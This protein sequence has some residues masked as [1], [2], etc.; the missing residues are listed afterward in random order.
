M[1]KPYSQACE[2]NKD[3]IL[4]VL[5]RHLGNVEDVLEIGSGTGQHAVHFARHLPH[6]TWRTSDQVAYHEGIRAWLEDSDLSNVLSPLTLNVTM[7]PWPVDSAAAVFSANTAHIMSWPMVEAFIS[8]VGRIL[9]ERGLFLLYGP[10]SYRGIH[11]S[12]SNARFDRSLREQDPAMGV[13]DF[14][15][16]DALARAASLDFVEDNAMPA[17]NRLLVWCRSPDQV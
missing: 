10:F 14:H 5:A 3:A 6:L 17:N 4:E 12:D 16:V 11:T 7:E 9:A 15:D 1:Y 8:G 2:N 13:R